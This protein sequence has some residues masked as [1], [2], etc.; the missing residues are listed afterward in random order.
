MTAIE[1]LAVSAYEFPTD[2]PEADG[3]LAW[4]ATTVV[5]VD[6]TAG[7]QRGIGYSYADAAAATVIQ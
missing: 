2:A 6:A 4:D 1:N 7:D 3:T 5:V